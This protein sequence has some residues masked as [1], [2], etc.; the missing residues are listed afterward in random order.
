MTFFKSAFHE[1]ATYEDDYED[2]GV[3]IIHYTP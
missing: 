1:M 3:P 2:C